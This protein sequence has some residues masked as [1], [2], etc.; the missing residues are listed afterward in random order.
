MENLSNKNFVDNK[1]F[2]SAQALRNQIRQEIFEQ[3]ANHNSCSFNELM[4]NLN[5]SRPKLAYHLQVLAKYNI[6]TNFYDKR[7]G[8]KDH[9]FYDL[10]AFGRELLTGSSPVQPTPT[11]SMNT[12]SDTLNKDLT[13]FRTIQ[14]VEYKSYKNIAL[15]HTNQTLQLIQDKDREY[16]DPL[17]DCTIIKKSSSSKEL[18]KVN[19]PSF[20]QYYISY[21][22][23]FKLEK[24]IVPQ[25]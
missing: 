9:S 2:W 12:A 4:N 1:L 19:L 8:V 16:D 11:A 22:R 21:K 5:L 15:K 20:K 6:I 24:K 23:P 17:L 13:N 7:D 14:R 25:Y 18:E 10:T 3:L